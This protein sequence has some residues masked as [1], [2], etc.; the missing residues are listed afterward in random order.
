MRAGN[1]T[2]GGCEANGVALFLVRVSEQRSVRN[3]I[4][5]LNGQ[6]TLGRVQIQLLYFLP[7]APATAAGADAAANATATATVCPRTTAKP[8]VSQ[9]FSIITRLIREI[10]L[11]ACS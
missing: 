7:A 8:L 5:L 4:A 9:S 11:A 3:Y 10:H 2:S 6:T 1:R